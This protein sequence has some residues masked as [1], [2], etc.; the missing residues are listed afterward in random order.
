M[1][2]K[3]IVFIGFLLLVKSTSLTAQ[4]LAY[5]SPGGTNFWLYTPPSYATGTQTHPLLISLHGK[6]EIGTDLTKLTSSNPQQ[7]PSRLIYLN[8]WPKDLPFIVVTPQLAPSLT[9]VNQQ[10]PA[11]YIDEV[12]RYVSNNFRVDPTRI[13]VTGLSL[14]GTGTWTYAAAYPQKVA[15]IIP[16]SG[17]CDLMKAC[18]VKDIPAW[19][20]HGDGDRTVTPSYS[21][22]MVNAINSCE[23]ASLYKRELKILH[24]RAHNG[25]SEIYNGTNGYQIFPWLLKFKKNSTGN[26]APYVNAGIDRQV[27]LRSSPLELPSDFFDSDG[28]ISSVLWKQISGTP[29]TLS[30][31]SD[32]LL[33]LTNL[34]LGTF[35]FE[36]TVTDNSGSTISDRVVLKVIDTAVPAVTKMTLVNGQTGID[37][38]TI[39][40]GMV[41][42]TGQSGVY[43]FNI[44]A[45]AT[46]D[47]A[48]V[49]FSV[50][51]D[52]HTRT[53][54]TPGPY[55]IKTLSS[56]PE[57]ELRK[58]E[59]LV[60]ATPY[61]RTSGSGL[62]GKSLCYKI[63]VK[64][65]SESSACSGAGKI[66][67][68][69]WAGIS[70][71]L[72]SNI[73]LSTPPATK[74]ELTIFETA[75]NV[76]DNYGVRIRGYVCPPETGY[77]TF[78]I[79]SDDRSELWLS[80]TANAIDKVKI[81]YV[82]GL[83]G[84]RQWTKYASQKSAPVLLQANTKY[85]IEA[86]HKESTGSD[87]L[88][89]G[90]QLPSGTLERPIQG[91]RLAPYEEVAI[92]TTFTAET[93]FPN[94]ELESE[95]VVSIYPNPLHSPAS[96]LY[97]SLAGVP[98]S[99]TVNIA[100]TSATGEEVLHRKFNCVDNCGTIPI[101]VE[102]R[103]ANGVY[104]VSISAGGKTYTK[105]LVIL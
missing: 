48:S 101:D 77:Y 7:M 22:D 3:V 67:K 61:T 75:A 71:S 99:A 41:I 83:T 5:T 73:P 26:T 72:V 63:I 68:E 66:F 46:S 70:G 93:A 19:V 23:P 103:L 100:V 24:A 13:Y 81:A 14:G 29:L 36:L 42:N 49:R 51:T 64:D 84:L 4:Q 104:L 79:S 56:T 8:R 16:I 80:T 45:D 43:E 97:I 32:K 6:G 17:R 34:V 87:N 11:D 25:W 15:A 10:W 2:Y 95:S 40:E 94:D 65:G 59:Y 89:V 91:F 53:V 62:A 1:L 39:T 38:G 76:W 12:V 102:T 35:E 54:N 31:T 47:A 28:T 18:A 78:W 37:I 50:N 33:K 98:G 57:W 21:V 88:S 20:F 69:V 92:A 82:N 85:Y 9:E 105:R 27:S 52:Q 44:R 96:T 58:G 30:N 55:L 86:L 74:T 60:C 90:W